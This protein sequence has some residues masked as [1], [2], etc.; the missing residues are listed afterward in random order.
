MKAQQ[1]PRSLFL[2][3]HRWLGLA[4]AVFLINA[5]LTGALLTFNTELDKWLN[6]ELFTVQPG[7][8]RLSPLELRERAEQLVPHA[9][10]NFVLLDKTPEHAAALSL[11][12]RTNPATGEDYELEN[13]ELFIN[14]YTGKE[15][16]Q[17]LWGRVQLDRPHVMAM[18]FRWHRTL[19]LPEPWGRYLLGGAAMLWFL[20]A[21]IGFYLTLPATRTR[22][23]SRWKPS[24]RVQWKAQL[25]KLSFD[26]HR[27]AGLWL[28][29]VLIVIAIS[30][31][32]MNLADE[33]FDPALKQVLPYHDPLAAA[34]PPQPG[35]PVNLS[36]EQGL[37]Q[38]RTLMAQHAQRDGFEIEKETSLSFNSGRNVYAYAVKSSQDIHRQGGETKVYLSAYDGREV[39]FTQP[40]AASGNA[41]ESWLMALHRARVGGVP[42]Q[43]FLSFV[44]LIVVM[45]S[46]TGFIVW[47]KRR[48]PARA[49]TGAASSI[50]TT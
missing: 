41:V 6:P 27:A 44:G 35:E 19:M 29:G 30:G 34:T 46:I 17:R 10:V 28:W 33:V 49:K 1:T 3:A 12:P 43:M 40:Y 20:S 32:Q 18:L 4:L 7:E 25:P 36:W 14:P 38:G 23:F 26:L 48:R 47:V 45:L 24:W 21:L 15:L 50:R 9:Q 39:G 5:G 8:H 31:V 2:T 22:F 42:Y 16:G 37:G 13:D 11:S